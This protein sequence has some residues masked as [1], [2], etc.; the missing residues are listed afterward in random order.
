MLVQKY[1]NLFEGISKLKKGEVHIDESVPPVAHATCR[2]PFYMRKQV[3][4]TQPG[5]T[6]N[7]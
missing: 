4:N 1:P 7:H 2:I 5:T 3:A 6:G